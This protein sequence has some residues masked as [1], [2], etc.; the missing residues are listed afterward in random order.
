MDRIPSTDLLPNCLWNFHLT[1]LRRHRRSKPG[2]CHHLIKMDTLTGTNE[3]EQ[4]DTIPYLSMRR[5]GA[6]TLKCLTLFP[7]ESSLDFPALLAPALAFCNVLATGTL[8][9]MTFQ[10]TSPVSN[11]RIGR[12]LFS[13]RLE[14]SRNLDAEVSPSTCDVICAAIGKHN[15]T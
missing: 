9:T 11:C 1:H 6:T 10:R 14:A 2:A 12:P 7:S 13:L 8:A 5:R 4:G 3:G 15:P